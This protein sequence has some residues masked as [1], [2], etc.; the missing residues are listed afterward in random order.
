MAL[1]ARYSLTIGAQINIKR[2]DGSSL[3]LSL[4]L[5]LSHPFSL[6]LSL[7]L[8]THHLSRFVFCRPSLCNLC[9]GRVHAAVISGSNDATGSIT[10]EW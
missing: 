3:S 4:S 7:S 5:S 2:S 9:A 6:C 1:L 8:L 10:V